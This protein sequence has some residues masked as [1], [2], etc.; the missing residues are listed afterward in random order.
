MNGLVVEHA[1]TRSVRDSAG[2][3]DATA[4]PDIGDPYYAP[5]PVRPFLKEVGADPGKLRIAF[6]TTAPNGVP[7][8]ADCIRAVHE[9]AKLCS[10]LG[11]VVDEATPAL[12]AERYVNS[13]TALWSV[14]CAEIIDG[15]AFL[16]G[17]KPSPNQ[18]EELTW[19]LAQQGRGISG[20][21]YLL[22]VSVLQGIGPPNRAILRRVRY[23]AHADSCGATAAARQ[24]RRTSWE[25]D[26][27]LAASCCIRSFHADLQ[28]DR[29]AR[30]VGALVLERRGA[31]GGHALCWAL[32]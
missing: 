26:V 32:W 7:I 21:A 24:L 2:L 8:H 18:F 29:P 10:D 19:A 23:L 14:G 20:P 15:A 11:H 13:F 17:R 30:D 1:V 25:S 22:A 4:G 28:H 12:D 16:T 3:L 6:T 31:A 9:A 27:R 5:P